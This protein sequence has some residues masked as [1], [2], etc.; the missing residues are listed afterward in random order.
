MPPM[1][2]KGL[3]PTGLTWESVFYIICPIKMRERA[4]RQ[5]TFDDIPTH[6]GRRAGAGQKRLGGRPSV[7]HRDRPVHDP[8]L[9]AHVTLRA[10][11][12]PASLRQRRVFAAV[13]DALGRASHHGFRLIQ[14]SVQSNH[15]HVLVEADSAPR[16]TRGLQGLAIR[17][18]RA[19]NR[20]LGRRGAVWA[21]RFHARWLASPREVR[22]AL[23]Y[24]LHNW[25]R[26][27][28]RD[29]GVDPCSSAPW[30]RGW[31][32]TPT[33]VPSSAPVAAART[34]LARWGWRRCGLVGADERPAGRGGWPK[35]TAGSS[36]LSSA[37]R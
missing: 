26:H 35:P 23:V 3:P 34:W 7:P 28:H 37:R 32:E 5:L 14:F 4:R 2:Q 18:A 12:L 29:C 33:L 36:A 20:A 22:N 15:L 9:P 1:P 17:V 13:R 19:V 24:V 27:G 6:G 10:A 11:A 30:F 16:F 8:R 31:K 21:E 25:R